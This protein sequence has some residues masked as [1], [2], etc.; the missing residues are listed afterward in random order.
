MKRII[1]TGLLLLGVVGPTYAQDPVEYRDVYYLNLEAEFKGLWDCF[2]VCYYTD[3][4]SCI[5]D[6]CRNIEDLSTSIIVYDEDDV[7][8][9][10]F[11]G[12]TDNIS[13]TRNTTFS[14]RPAKIKYSYSYC[15]IIDIDDGSTTCES[16][17][18]P[19]I[20]LSSGDCATASSNASG[21]E[22]SAS[23]GKLRHY[24]NQAYCNENN[25]P[26]SGVGTGCTYRWF[27]AE[28]VDDPDF[29]LITQTTGT[30]TNSILLGSILPDE[31]FTGNYSIKS[32]I[33][34][35]G[36]STFPI[37]TDE[38]VYEI[39]SCSPKLVGEIGAIDASCSYKD[40]GS[41]TMVVDRPVI[42]REMIVSVF[43]ENLVDGGYEFLTQDAIS[44]L[45]PEGSN[46]KYT[47]NGDGL[48]EG[49]YQVKYQTY[50]TTTDTDDIGDSNEFESLEPHNFSIRAPTLFSFALDNNNITDVTCYD[51]SNGRVVIGAT[52]GS[53]SYNYSL[54]NGSWTTLN[55]A[56]TISGLEAKTYTL[57]VRDSEG[58]QY[59]DG[60]LDEI[61]VP[62]E[63]EEPD[64][65]TVSSLQ[66]SP[67]DC[68]DGTDGAIDITVEGGAGGYSYVWSSGQTTQDLPSVGA[69]TYSV[70][71]EDSDDCQIT[72]N[73]IEVDQP[74]QLALASSTVNDVSCY[75]YEDGSIEE[76]T[77]EGGNSPYTYTWID[78]DDNTIPTTTG[79]II[80]LKAGDYHLTLTDDK[81]CT[82]NPTTI[83][84]NV[85]EPDPLA[86]TLSQDPVKC[87]GGSDGSL[88]IDVTG[89][90]D[91][92]QYEFNFAGLT[93][94]TGDSHTLSGL[95]A[96]TYFIDVEDHLGCET[97]GSQSITVTQPVAPITIT[98][99]FEQPS[100]AGGTNG[101]LVATI[102]GGTS[103][104]AGAYSYVWAN[105]AGDNLNAQ[106]TAT[107]LTD[108]YQ[109]TLEGI[110]TG[111]YYLTIQDANYTVATTPDNCTIVEDVSFL[112]E[113]LPL[114]ASITITT[115]ISCNSEN[116]YGNPSSD[117]ILEVSAL[118]GIQLQPDANEGLAYYYTWKKQ[119]ASG[120]WEVLP[121][122]TTHVATGLADGNY[123]V[124]I[125]DANGIILGT[126]VNNVL[127]EAQ[128]E[129]FIFEEPDLLAVNLSKLDVYCH[130]GSDGW[131]EASISGGTIDYE[132]RWDTGDQTLRSEGLSAG[133]YT[134]SITDDRDCFVDASITVHQPETP[135]SI[136]YPF[137]GFPSTGGASDGWVMAQIEGGTAFADQ[138]YRYSWVDADGNTLAAQTVTSFSAA[139]TFQIQLNNIAQGTYALTIEDGAYDLTTTPA[140]CTVI[141]S[142]FT[143]YDPIEGS[144]AMSRPI[145]CNQN[146]SFDNPWSDG[147][148]QSTIT[149]GLPFEGA[150]PY[151]YH[152][153]KRN[154][155]TG[156]YEA[157][158]TQTSGEAIDLST[159]YYA[160]NVE[161]ALGNI[162]GIYDSYTLTEATDLYY[163]FEEPALFEV[164]MA[165]TPISCDA[166]NDGSA[167]ITVSGGSSDYAVTW[168]NGA[169]TLAQ[170]SLIAG[171]YIAY[172]TDARGCE[173][174]GQVTVA[175]PG[176]LAIDVLSKGDP[177]C[178]QGND[179]A[180]A[181][182]VSGGETPYQYY[183]PHDGN[184]TTAQTNL[185]AGEYTFEITDDHGCKAIQA[186]SLNDPDPIL[187]D[188][189]DDRT[190]CT[191]QSH[192]LDITTTDTG[193][194]Y[195]WQSEAGF[196]SSEAVVSLTEAGQY[197]ATLTTNEGCI[198]RDTLEVQTTTLT[199]DA[200]FLVSSQA[201]AGE[202]ILMVNTSNPLS[203]AISWILP[204]GATL[205]SQSESAVTLQFDESGSYEVTLRSQEGACYQDYTKNIIVQQARSLTDIGDAED[206]FISE[207][208]SFPNPSRGSFT[209]SVSLT[210]I[211]TISLRL[212]NLVSNHAVDDKI[213]SG[214]SEYEI[215]YDT[216]LP[217]GI[218]Y[219]LLETPKG[220]EIRK[221]VLE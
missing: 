187:L 37:S 210:E 184:A 151:I 163:H 47:W 214:Q 90:N 202:E 181:L 207:Y 96:S 120:V 22:I 208:T 75:G 26:F 204:E 69:G 117:G 189:G 77:F 27:G 53:N 221:I 99:G 164:A 3:F 113:P 217:A 9:G 136:T 133:E 15:L 172:L 61:S 170:T 134:V 28:T 196:T 11:N 57:K 41:F 129:E 6:G 127:S 5:V 212:F 51:G 195:L 141:E 155:T 178:Y 106:V 115:P 39:N 82:T 107:P 121:T 68:F 146:N 67:V 218:Y 114:E 14:T 19:T 18:S 33:S 49:N 147:Q 108:T 153:K 25:F 215:N 32:E 55:T 145:S 94:M 176:G 52:G 130:E 88:T 111:N 64:Q 191:G 84:R 169:E 193:A 2:R 152:W 211:A 219:L 12:G 60:D 104:T 149:G 171:T 62:F 85:P 63:I 97:S 83:T 174:T 35:D 165:S 66:V 65:I 188:I 56:K 159:G 200:Q 74:D 70:T 38:T 36:G 140:G 80:L 167:S 1:F 95:S 138:S 161:D 125:E 50:L 198:G 168:S 213:Q 86:F 166:G 183:W 175:Q 89:G 156:A 92:Y 45:T 201:F 142:V 109:A 100:H 173:T 135:L 205:V 103:T 160:L 10:I 122:Q 46:Y 91:S 13:W 199:I 209:V 102:A 40:D 73:G 81:G 180:I 21:Y 8:L 58:C 31:N 206:P 192:D 197:I 54:N 112:N 98:Y 72:S 87:H 123:A 132:T 17:S 78:E 194:T 190:L 4:P 128:D 157:I 185:T 43:F 116:I 34:L 131:V 105:E 144:L 7:T 59:L 44:S 139:G 143:L 124:N 216:Q 76:V 24:E 158:T 48:P 71:I 148:I 150:I 101:N 137:F 29:S 154:E 16:L 42:N 93:A 177:T 126:Y 179:G 110:G 186:I 118:G 79:N 220:S 30:E 182:E 23:M 20:S 203:S 162:M 119:N